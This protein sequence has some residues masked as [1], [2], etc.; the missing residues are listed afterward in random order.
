MWREKQGSTQD[1]RG[2]NPERIHDW[3]GSQALHKKGHVP[4]S[5]IIFHNKQNEASE[6]EFSFKYFMA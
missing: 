3:R 6:V 1:H 4:L 2:S 5:D